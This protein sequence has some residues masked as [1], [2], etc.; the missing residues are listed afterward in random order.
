MAKRQSAISQS[1]IQGGKKIAPQKDRPAFPERTNG[2]SWDDYRIMLA[3]AESGSLRAASRALSMSRNTVKVHLDMMERDLGGALFRADHTGISLTP[4]GAE[5]SSVARRMHMAEVHLPAYDDGDTERAP[6]EVRITTTEGL[7]TFWLMPRIAD[8]LGS[9]PDTRASIQCD[10]RE[11][12]TLFR[13]VDLAV[14]L[15]RPASQD[16][17]IQRIGTLHLTPFATQSYLDRFG[18]PSLD[19]LDDHSLIWQKAPQV[20]D[21]LLSAFLSPERIRDVLKVVTNTS[22]SHYAAVESGAGFGFLPN[23]SV[24]FSEKLVPIPLNIPLRRDIFLVSHSETVPNP[25]VRAARDWLRDAFDARRFPWFGDEA[26][27]PNLIRER[28]ENDVVV[29]MFSSRARGGKKG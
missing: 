25:R 26:F 24:L 4:L 28:S 15:D 10:M 14:Q 22:T 5:L 3:V 19:D 29:D 17:M 18:T 12:D 6:N 27:D 8:F 21:D 23:F 16:L 2:R 13:N 7:G 20:R 11:V 9:N 1:S